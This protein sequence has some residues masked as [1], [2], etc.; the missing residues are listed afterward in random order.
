MLS[1]R[2]QLKQWRGWRILFLHFAVELLSEFLYLNWLS[3][4]ENFEISH[5]SLNGP[6][7]PMTF[8]L[9]PL[10]RLLRIT[11]LVALWEMRYSG[12]WI[13]ESNTTSDEV[14]FYNDGRC[15]VVPL[16]AKVQTWFLEMHSSVWMAPSLAVIYSSAS[17]NFLCSPDTLGYRDYLLISHLK[18]VK[19]PKWL[20]AS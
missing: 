3:W 4:K 12:I 20:G 18:A 14:A 19:D 16:G 9:L 6:I 17:Q 5:C 8:H 2:S 13:D 7:C 1:L 10:P 15:N 11:C